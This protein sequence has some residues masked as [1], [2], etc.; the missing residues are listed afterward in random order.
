MKGSKQN[1]CMHKTTFAMPDELFE[2]MSKYLKSRHGDTRG[3]MAIFIQN[4]IRNELDRL[5]LD[6]K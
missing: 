2:R 6:K 4:A 5:Q 1:N 3:K